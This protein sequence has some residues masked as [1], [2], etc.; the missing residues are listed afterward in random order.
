MRDL[1]AAR[2][3]VLLSLPDK[4]HPAQAEELAEHFTKDFLSATIGKLP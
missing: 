3:H 4:V 2:E 1:A